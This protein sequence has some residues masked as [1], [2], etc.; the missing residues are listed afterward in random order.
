MRLSAPANTPLGRAL[1]VETSRV[2][3]STAITL[4]GVA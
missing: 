3:L 4:R 1:I 2:K